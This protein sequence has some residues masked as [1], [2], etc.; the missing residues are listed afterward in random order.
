M[1]P[2]DK[3]C[4]DQRLTERAEAAEAALSNCADALAAALERG[5]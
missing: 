4:S 2:Q 1:T 5:A 3:K